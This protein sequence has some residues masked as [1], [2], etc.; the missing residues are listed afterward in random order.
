MPFFLLCGALFFWGMQAY[1]TM[2]EMASLAYPKLRFLSQKLEQEK[3]AVFLEHLM[4]NPCSLFST[5]LLGINF[6]LVCS[7]ECMRQLFL[8]MQWDSRLS[9][10][11]QLLGVLLC[12]ELAPLFAARKNPEFIF[13]RGRR[14]F[15]FFS[16]IS[17]PISLLFEK[18]LHYVPNPTEKKMHLTKEEIKKGVVEEGQMKEIEDNLSLLFSFR[19]MK[20]KD[21]LPFSQM[22]STFNH[23]HIMSC[24]EPVSSALEFFVKNPYAHLSC[25]DQKNNI[26]GV[27]DYSTILN[28]LLNKKHNQD[29]VAD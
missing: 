10:W 7:S 11:I 5:S 18:V 1:F 3:D 20:I 21:I 25:I 24:Q 19:T 12:A 2:M 28:I 23:D 27:L 15:S 4:I 8:A 6:S 14:V 16:K 17:K 22:I 29:D 9:I 13:G 26:L